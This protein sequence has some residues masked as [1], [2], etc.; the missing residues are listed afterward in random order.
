MSDEAYADES[1]EA[2]PGVYVVNEF[3]PMFDAAE[4]T[5]MGRDIFTQRSQVTNDFGIEWMRRHLGE[6]YRIHVLDF[7][8]KN[9]MHI[10]GTFIPLAP[11]KVLVNPK[12]PCIT[13]TEKSFFTFNGEEKT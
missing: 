4:F 7:Q 12:R 6:D 1:Y 5:R 11:G 9:A 13:G 8:D 3:E 10:D 2:A